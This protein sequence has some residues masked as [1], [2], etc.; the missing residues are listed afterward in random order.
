MPHL[1]FGLVKCK[2]FLEESAMRRSTRRGGFTLLELLVTMAIIVVLG[3]IVAP[4]LIGVAGD[5]PIKQ[6]TD[7]IRGHIAN[8]RSHA[9]LEGQ[10]YRMAISPDGLK[11]RVLPATWATPQ[12]K[13]SMPNNSNAQPLVVEETFPNDVT[14]EMIPNVDTL[15]TTDAGGWQH[16]ATFLPNGTCQESLTTIRIRKGGSAPRVIQLRGLTG[17]TTVSLE[18]SADAAGVNR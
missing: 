10:A 16:V 9:I 1:R 5:S 18:N 14:A 13:Q 17:V 4:S 7:Q 6:A 15:T 8:A 2:L 12:D 3:A 11:V